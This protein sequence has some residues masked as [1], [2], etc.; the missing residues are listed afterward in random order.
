MSNRIPL[1]HPGV[2]LLEE[3]IEPYGLTPSKVA[4]M[5]N[6][7]RRR[8]YDIVNGKRDI[9]IDTAMRLALFFDTTARFWINLQRDY[10]LRL[11]KRSHQG[12]LESEVKPLSELAV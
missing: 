1:E 3:F 11:A 6:V 5:I 7:D 9:S 10:D 2:I 8:M 4:R 12:S